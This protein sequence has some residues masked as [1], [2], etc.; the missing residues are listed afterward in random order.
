M[1]HHDAH[2]LSM[3]P[4]QLQQVVAYVTSGG[5]SV[6]PTPSAPA[7]VLF[8]N[9]RQ[10]HRILR[11]REARAAYLQQLKAAPPV[12]KKVPWV[13]PRQRG[14]LVG[15]T[16]T[17]TDGSHHDPAPP[18]PPQCLGAFDTVYQ[19]TPSSCRSTGSVMHNQA[20]SP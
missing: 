8:V 7:Q 4:E 16:V 15:V 14:P 5:P 10:V 3:S 1:H 6:A 17:G 12:P 9:P 20:I 2:Q 13:V 19:C 18:P 11:R